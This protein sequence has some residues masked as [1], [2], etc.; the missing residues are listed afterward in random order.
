MIITQCDVSPSKVRSVGKY[1]IIANKIIVFVN[2]C[3]CQLVMP[4]FY[5]GKYV[6]TAGDLQ[7]VDSTVSSGGCTLFEIYAEYSTIE[8]EWSYIDYPRIFEYLKFTCDIS[9]LYGVSVPMYYSIAPE[10]GTNLFKMCE[11]YGIYWKYTPW[12]L[13]PPTFE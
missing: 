5:R 11:L 8:S 4:I 6:Y 7:I 12:D 2:H 1:L 13:P 3:T 9:H 10:Y